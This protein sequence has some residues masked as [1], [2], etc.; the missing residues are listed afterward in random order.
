MVT[1]CRLCAQARYDGV[2][3]QLWY[4]TRDDQDTAIIVADMAT[5][6]HAN[7]DYWF[8]GH[9]AITTVNGLSNL[10]GT[11]ELLQPAVDRLFRLRRVEP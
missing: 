4:S 7:M 6:D 10:R 11:R 9:T 5:F 3:Y 2:G 8:Y 1:S